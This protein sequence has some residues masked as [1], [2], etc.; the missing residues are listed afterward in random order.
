M[1]KIIAITLALSTTAVAAVTTKYDTIDR[2]PRYS[3]VSLFTNTLCKGARPRIKKVGPLTFKV[4][5]LCRNELRRFVLKY[6]LS[7][8]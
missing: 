4:K 1:L 8:G 6:T 7:A 5:Y 3:D 2:A